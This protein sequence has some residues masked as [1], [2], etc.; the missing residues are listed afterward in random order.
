MARSKGEGSTVK[1]RKDGRFVCHVTIAGKRTFF[2]GQSRK[3][4]G[5]KMRAFLSS[6]V[7]A[8]PKKF[9]GHRTINELLD[10]WLARKKKAIKDRTY[11]S[12]E[13]V[14]RLHIKPALGE[15]DPAKLTARHV[16]ALLDALEHTVKAGRKDDS[17]DMIGPRT[18]QIV[19]T[20]L[21]Q[22]FRILN[23]C[24]MLTVPKPKGEKMEI[25][26][27]DGEQARTFLLHV[28]AVN[29]AAA[30]LYR[31]ALTTGMRKGEMLALT[32]NDLNF[33]NGEVRITKTWNE[34]MLK[35]TSPKTKS[36]RRTIIMPERT[37]Q[38]LRAYIMQVG[39]RGD[40]RIFTLEPRNLTKS[41]HKAMEAAK[42]PKIRFHDLR[43]SYATV[44]LAAGV[45]VKVISLSLGH[46]SVKITLDTYAH[47]LPG[48]S[49]AAAEKIDA[50]IG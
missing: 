38:A 25:Q 39:V 28:D 12:Y 11:G 21:S 23:P 49:E 8:N 19:Y 45:N 1:Q 50:A 31:L 29:D 13:S 47:V 33:K 26:P 5:D 43:H 22:A 40:S 30:A 35:A 2:Y 4:A 46:A 20:T 27:W 15:L 41:M 14:V 36:S 6:P 9:D 10:S 34:K 18:G 7:A 32:V 48:Q 17:T 42:V 3:D 44:A 16:V 37:R 24:L